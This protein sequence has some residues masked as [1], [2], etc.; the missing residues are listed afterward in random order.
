M[1]TGIAAAVVVATMV[2]GACGSD[3]RTSTDEGTVNTTA[4][5]SPDGTAAPDGTTATGGTTAPETD[6]TTDQLPG[7]GEGD[8]VLPA[9]DVPVVQLKVQGLFPVIEPFLQ[10]GWTTIY[11]D[12]TVLLPTRANAFAQPQVWP[13]EVGHLDT[14]DVAALLLHAGGYE[15]L[16]EPD[17]LS[18]NF[19]V[20]DAP[21][22]TLVL[23]WAT[24]SVTHE[25]IG[26]G[27][28][29]DPT[30][31]Y[32]DAL[33]KLTGEIADLV[34]TSAA[35]PDDGSTWPVFYDPRAV[36]VVAIEVTTGDPGPGTT[37]V[38]EWAGGDADLA[39]WSSC[40]T[41]DDP[42]TVSFL[43]GQL[44]GPMYQQGDHLYR[45]ASRVHPPGTSCD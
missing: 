4:A 11:P 39:T 6:D 35:P 1:G 9:D 33:M 29:A 38:V 45:I 44:A 15:L 23:T 10:T 31:E 36:D 37:T 3:D 19:G 26:L 30:D 22:T 12:G 7:W 27:L 14:V 5:S 2:F 17:G 18:N 25:A 24:G 41:V 13:Y 20:A 42:A 43:V 40:T 34:N 28:G 32:R 21:K 8:V 16:D